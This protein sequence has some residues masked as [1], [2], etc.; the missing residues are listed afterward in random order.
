M[1]KKRS[2]VLS[3]LS[4]KCPRCREGDLY[5]QKGVFPLRRMMTMNE[6]CPVCGQKTEL[7]P[8]FY[9]GTGY[10]SYGLSVALAVFNIV[11]Y[12]VLIGFSWKDN[13]MWYYLGITIAMLIILQPLIMRLSRSLYI[14]FFVKFDPDAKDNVYGAVEETNAVEEMEEV[15]V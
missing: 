5:V 12:V 6:R 15:T 9:Y 13:S 8:G 14:S 2:M 7:E 4:N 11:W 10:V 1:G 3:M